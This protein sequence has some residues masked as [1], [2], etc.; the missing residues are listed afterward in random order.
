[1]T[2]DLLCEL[3]IASSSYLPNETEVRNTIEKFSMLDAPAAIKRITKSA[4]FVAI[5]P[6]L[7]LAFDGLGTK[8]ISDHVIS[9]LDMHY[10]DVLQEIA[11]DDKNAQLLADIISGGIEV[12][13]DANR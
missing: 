1:M 4:E 8:T 2:E 11:A 10:P 5:V 7:E 3:L 12:V 9:F 13:K 6:Q